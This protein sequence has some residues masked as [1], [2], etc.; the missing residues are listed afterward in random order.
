MKKILWEPTDEFVNSSNLMQFSNWLLK[1]KKLSF[2]NYEDIHKWSIKNIDEFWIAVVQYF[3]IEYSGWDSRVVRTDVPMP[4]TKW[5]EDMKLNYVQH[6]FSQR[7]ETHPA[8]IYSGEDKE[9]HTIS[10]RE[11]EREVIGFQQFLIDNGVERGDFVVGY[12]A[13]IPQASIA[14]LAAAGLGAVWSCC[15]PDFG[16]DSVVD[17]FSQLNPKIIVAVDGYSYNNKIYDK[18]GEL[19]EIASRIDSIEKI[20][21]ARNINSDLSLTA[22]EYTWNQAV[23]YNHAELKIEQVPFNHPLWVLFSSGTTG[24]PKAIIHSHGG[25]LLEHLKYHSFHNDTKKGERYFWFTTT[26]WMMWNYLHA[27]WLVGATVVLYDGS[28][29][30]SS[31]DI[32][33]DYAEQAQITHFGTSA[34]YIVACMKRGLSPKSQHNLSSL[35]SI[36]STGAPLPPEAFDYV[37]KEIKS[38]IWLCSMSGGTDVC[39]AFVGGSPWKPVLYGEIQCIALA[40]SLESWDED[41]N[42]VSG[43]LGEMVITKPMPSMPVGFVADE[44][45]SRYASSYF[46]MYPGIWRHGDWVKITDSLGIII[47]GRSDATLNRHGVRIGTAE[48]YNV[49]NHIEAIADS[50]V[51]NLELRDGDHYMP[52]F[53]KLNDGHLLTDELI[54]RIKK[55]LRMNGSPRH[56]PDAIFSI[57]DVPTTIS[58]KK[59]EAPIK[60]ILMGMSVEKAVKR[61]AMKN[62]ESLEYFLDWYRKFNTQYDL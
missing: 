57:P 30:L 5:F 58:G 13:N 16:G 14:F 8:I 3:Q 31:L 45:Y 29:A 49:L 53:V 41:G 52:L 22:N 50:L 19:R 21:W 59:M 15:S 12:M 43:E 48:L 25:N 33:W 40:C 46:S 6:I 39:T 61:D 44:E 36:S 47:Y 28:P 26:G 23:S 62:P 2:T 10:W 4:R 35:R 11:L 34:P 7:N 55:E 60:K 27:S 51:V 38:D 54:T 9:I 24:K 20:V 1:Q 18:R 37:Y 56:V 17:R 42:P 32:L